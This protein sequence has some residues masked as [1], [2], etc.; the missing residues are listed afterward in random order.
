EIVACFARIEAV[1][2]PESLSYFE[3]TTLAALL[4]FADKCVDFALLEVGLGGRLDAVNLIDP[5]CCIITNIALDHEDW[6]GKGRESIGAEK[7]GI[8]RAATPFVFCDRDPPA[9]VM[10]RAAS[11]GLT[12][13][14][15]EANFIAH[16][17]ADHWSFQGQAPNGEII[18]RDT[19]PIPNLFLDNVVGAL[20][21]LAC[22][23]LLPADDVLRGALNDLG[24]GGRFEKRQ[25][26]VSGRLV[27]L[28]AAHNV[29]AAELLARRLKTTFSV[30]DTRLQIEAESRP[31]IR[32]VLAAMADKNIEDIVRALDPLVDIWYIAAFEGSR[33]AGAQE[34][35][36]R[37]ST[38]LPKAMIRPY[39][40]V[41]SAFRAACND[42]PDEHAI[43]VVTGSFHTLAEVAALSDLD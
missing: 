10:A 30:P 3:F 8:L 9:S 33:A 43:I 42:Q 12:P 34:I 20:Q 14:A 19:L 1:R 5:D 26:L 41:L 36:A 16:E 21:A 27:I 22:L 32:L 29:A 39:D 18:R 38:A 24:L 11:L 15:I 31:T 28:D 6:L 2:E 7:A 37:V 40:S 23:D 17:S 25:D 35:H 13:F 4:L